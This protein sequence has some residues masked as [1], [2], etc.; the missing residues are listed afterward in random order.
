[1]LNQLLNY[2]SYQKLIQPGQKTLLA[3]SGGIDSMVL[4]QLFSQTGL[5]F[6]IAHCN[7]QLRASESE[8]DQQ[9]VENRANDYQVVCHTKRF[10]TEEYAKKHG[11]SIQMAARSLRRAW[12][13]E[14]IETE[15]IDLIATAHHLNDSLETI[16]FNLAKGTGISGLRGILPKSE[17]YIRPL[18]FASR[19]M[20]FD[21]AQ[22]N[23]IVWR[24]D[25][26]NSAIKYHRNLIRHKIVPELKNINPSL[27][28]TFSVSLEKIA[29]TERIYKN[30]IS[31]YKKE[32][33]QFSVDGFSIDKKK[34]NT[35]DEA[36][37]ILF[38]IL[39]EYGFNFHQVREILESMHGQSGKTF[40]APSYQLNVDRDFL[41]IKKSAESPFVE[42]TINKEAKQITTPF[43]QLSFAYLDAKK[44]TFNDDNNKAFLDAD[45]IKFPLKIRHW[46]HG[47]RFQPL[48]M[49]HKK[50]LSDFMIDE[51]I[52]LNLKNQVL[53]LC[54]EE[55]LV[56]VIGWRIDDRY[57]IT[58]NTSL[59]LSIFNRTTDDQPV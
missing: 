21:Y 15:K 18:M 25:K 39:E 24:E 7:F 48:G 51:K 14:L 42:M 28:A 32:L 56:W 1:M 6:E 40:L 9:L 53:V 54:S 19:E 35:L 12:F 59:A 16:L 31:K 34:L 23:Q 26:S 47:D 5:P 41:F 22:I 46:Q 29:A 49:R 10:A 36:P 38:E 58:K 43:G 4:V 45:K 27:E 20:I 30:A 57:K 2:I 50:K 3:V 13:D 17:K 44:V 33:V 8:G 11:I 52:P 55:N 37:I